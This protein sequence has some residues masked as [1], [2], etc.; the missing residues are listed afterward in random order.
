MM[1]PVLFS[2]PFRQCNRNYNKKTRIQIESYGKKYFSKSS[3]VGILYLVTFKIELCHV[4]SPIDRYHI[5][6]A[7]M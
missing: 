1:M 4:P 3:I 7:I 6:Y 2:R 5:Q